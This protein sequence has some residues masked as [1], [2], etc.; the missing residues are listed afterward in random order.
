MGDERLDEG[1]GFAD[2]GGWGVAS[3]FALAASDDG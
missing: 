3:A 1:L 2:A